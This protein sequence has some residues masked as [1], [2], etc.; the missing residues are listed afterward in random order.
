MALVAGRPRW[1]ITVRDDTDNSTVVRGT[2]VASDDVDFL[3]GEVAGLAA[4][5]SAIT[6]C[7]VVRIGVSFPH[8]DN[9]PGTPRTTLPMQAL[10][11]FNFQLTSDSTFFTSV[12]TPLNPDWLLT[13]GPLAG[14]GIDLSN[15]DVASFTSLITDGIWVDPFAEDIGPIYSAFGEG[16]I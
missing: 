8:K 1:T 2:L 6:G 14:V 13:T 5:M 16:T 9:E 12:S 7:L 4:A 10:A 11:R 15:S 3:M